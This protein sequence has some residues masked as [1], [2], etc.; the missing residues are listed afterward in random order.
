MCTITLYLSLVVRIDYLMTCSGKLPSQTGAFLQS[1]T[2]NL[3]PK[4][5]KIFLKKSSTIMM[6]QESK[7]LLLTTPCLKGRPLAPVGEWSPTSH[8]LVTN[9]RRHR[10]HLASGAAA[11]VQASPPQNDDQLLQMFANKKEQMK[12]Q[13]V[14]SNHDW[15][16]ATLKSR[17]CHPRIGGIEVAHQPTPGPNCCLQEHPDTDAVEKQAWNRRF[18]RHL[19]PQR[20][21]PK[22]GQG[23]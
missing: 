18:S 16:Q 13:Q 23:G 9:Y 21:N 11:N 2:Q 5:H 4:N 3:P 1:R 22:T 8:Q 12:E 14:R 10:F 17:K 15:E 7:L 20:V 19:D 6:A